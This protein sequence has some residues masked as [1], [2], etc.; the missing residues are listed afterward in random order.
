MCGVEERER[1]TEERKCVRHQENVHQKRRIMTFG[2]PRRGTC[3][4]ENA[5]VVVV[6]VL[7]VQKHL[8]I[9]SQRLQSF[10]TFKK[11]L[12]EKLNFH[13]VIKERF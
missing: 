13:F 7:F 6:V 10:T 3:C 8:L 5:C 9:M 1:E 2:N 12:F 4:F 11:N